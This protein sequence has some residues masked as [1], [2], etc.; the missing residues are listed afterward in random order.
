MRSLMQD[1][2]EASDTTI[3]YCRP[4]PKR[5]IINQLLLSVDYQAAFWIRNCAIH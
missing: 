5:I 3:S 1:V 2:Q 4:E